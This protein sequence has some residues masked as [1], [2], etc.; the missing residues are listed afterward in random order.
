M[1]VVA[2]GMAAAFVSTLC[3]VL[4]SSSR[5]VTSTAVALQ[6]RLSM[7]VGFWGEGLFEQ[8]ARG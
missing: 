8:L 4:P 5:N 2:V 6:V 7:A 3:G 1:L